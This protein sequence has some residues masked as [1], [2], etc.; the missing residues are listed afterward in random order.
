[1]IT[2][3]TLDLISLN[4][5]QLNVMKRLANSVSVTWFLLITKVILL[6]LKIVWLL[7]IIVQ[8]EAY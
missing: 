7:S 5:V 6:E 2:Q 4:P 8:F 1:M 3:K